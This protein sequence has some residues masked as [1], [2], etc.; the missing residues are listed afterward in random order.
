MSGDE[1]KVKL[2]IE[3]IEKLSTLLTA[4][5]GLVAALAWNSAIQNAFALF[6]G[7]SESLPAQ[8]T[9]A[10]IVT[11]IAVYITFLIGR[12]KTALTDRL[13]KK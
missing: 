1:K 12:A 4:A 8:I 6:F 5:F 7:Q 9:Y 13:D 10:V 2:R 3:F 11:G